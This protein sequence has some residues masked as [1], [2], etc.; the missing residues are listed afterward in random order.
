MHIV[1]YSDKVLIVVMADRRCAY[2]DVAIDFA[3][4]A[5][6]FGRIE[7]LHIDDQSFRARAEVTCAGMYSSKYKSILL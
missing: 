1:N 3:V 4:V 2:G 6:V 5:V 7:R